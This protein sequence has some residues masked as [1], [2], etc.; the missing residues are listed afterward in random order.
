MTVRAVLVVVAFH[1]LS[2]TASYGAEIEFNGFASIVAG[3]NL[4]DDALVYEYDHEL[5][6]K[7]DSVF[8]VQAS[9]DL[10]D[11]LTA[12]L[13]LVSRGKDDFSVE[14]EW[15]YL[16]YK[17]S[18]HSTIY[19]GRVR[20]PFYR[21]SD[22]VVVAYA[23]TWIRPPQGFYFIPFNSYEGVGYRFD[24][25]S[26]DLE[27]GFNIQLSVSDDDFN[28]EN[29]GPPAHFE[30]D[31]TT[32]I[33]ASISYNAWHSRAI[34]ARFN[35]AYLDVFDDNFAALAGALQLNG[36]GNVA[37]ALAL[38]DQEIVFSGIGLD[39]DFGNWSFT[40]EYAHLEMPVSF[41]SDQDSWYVGVGYRHGQLTYYLP[42]GA[43]ENIPHSEIVAMLPPPA[44]S[45]V[46]DPVNNV[47]LGMAVTGAT[48][49]VK[50]DSKTTIV[51]IRYDFH[52][53]A[54]LKF[55]Y[56]QYDDKLPS[57]KDGGILNIGVDLVF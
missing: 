3:T 12:T 14:A 28:L 53:S 24:G 40:S 2:N 32:L 5:S 11:G 49:V 4:E 54:A 13:Q 39:A 6:F 51:G 25:Y 29:N 22:F 18:E 36:L 10:A 33:E 20:T 9:S 15:A 31:Y 48:S 52:R 50:E 35:G 44:A 8:A 37:S 56:T 30:T 43:D 47:T 34:W 38:A 46:I 23:Y 16:S 26:G 57:N 19:A 1:L 45:A 41:Q 27:Y 55:E 42:F 17:L 21:Y 7:P